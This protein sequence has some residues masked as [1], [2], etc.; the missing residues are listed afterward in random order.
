M[1]AFLVSQSQGAGESLW[2]WPS[3]VSLGNGTLELSPDFM[4]A[5]IGAHAS[6]IVTA[7]AERYAKLIA[8][9]GYGGDDGRASSLSACNISL[10]AASR[11][12]V[13]ETDESYELIVS[14]AS[15]CTITA[16]NAWGAL[17][18]METFTQLLQRG[19]TAA[20]SGGGVRMHG[21]PVAII[22]R[23]AFA[24]RGIML[25]AARHFL[26]LGTLRAALDAASYNKMNVLHLHVNDA[27]SFPFDGVP[28]IARGAY[29]PAATYS[30][31]DVGEL[32]A[33]GAAR[34]VRVL[35]ELESPGHA[36]SYGAGFPA[37]MAAC[38]QHYNYNFNDWALNPA[39]N[40][41]YEVVFQLMAAAAAAAP[42][43]QQL[44]LGGDEVVYGC[45]DQDA[46]VSAF[47]VA[48]G[49]TSND[50]LFGY[51]VSRQH[52]KAAEL[53]VMPIHWHE[54]F[55]GK[56]STKLNNA[57]RVALPPFCC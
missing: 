11:A 2:P 49:I 28:G 10:S 47:K 1:L 51:Y 34:G 7:A 15:R 31:Q 27:Q 5:Q 39:L 36:A 17:H 40:Q 6:P 44:H 38:Q 29:A 8:A 33:Y 52:A 30:A 26:P 37:I 20:N 13:L 55:L 42:D 41:T 54:V 45:W 25:D 18:A 53:G 21:A 4:F 46:S 14:A 12:T 43:E 23:P 22:D 57:W 19:G 9:A 3:S 32:V 50:A 48:Q 16:T 56:M 24:H 35:L